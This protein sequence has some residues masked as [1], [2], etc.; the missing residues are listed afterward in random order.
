M[1]KNANQIVKQNM[2]AA[3]KLPMPEQ[4]TVQIVEDEFTPSEAQNL[5][6]NIVEPQVNLYKVRAM[7]DWESDHNY[8]SSLSDRKTAQLSDNLKHIEEVIQYAKENGYQVSLTGSID[9]RLVRE[10]L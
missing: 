5:V 6:R 10:I 9:V 4:K 7:T 1:R 8:G 3:M 2:I